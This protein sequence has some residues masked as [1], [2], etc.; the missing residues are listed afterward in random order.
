MSKQK[1]WTLFHGTGID[2]ARKILKEG[3]KKVSLR[4]LFLTPSKKVAKDF[5]KTKQ[6]YNVQADK[7]NIP[8]EKG[9]VLKVKIT[10][11]DFQ[12]QLKEGTDKRVV[13]IRRENLD[14]AINENWFE[15]E[16]Y[17]DIS[18]KSIKLIDEFKDGFN[19]K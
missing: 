19:L 5:S 7:S 11:K 16:W 3:L 4:P 6:Q 1:E 15:Y 9:V 13:D 10:E 14:K 17:R 12:K 18:A 2:E 8:R